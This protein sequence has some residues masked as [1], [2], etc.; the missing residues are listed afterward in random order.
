MRQGVKAL[1]VCTAED[2]AR[3]RRYGAHW[4]WLGHSGGMAAAVASGANAYGGEKAEGPR[5]YQ[6][7]RFH[8]AKHNFHSSGP[9]LHTCGLPLAW[10]EGGGV[11]GCDAA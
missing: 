8:L 4:R 1:G 2:Y 6:W 7:L 3:T 5:R 9:R 10:A 11:A